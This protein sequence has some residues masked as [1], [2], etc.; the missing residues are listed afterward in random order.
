M[1]EGSKNENTGILCGNLNVA[2][3][4]SEILQFSLCMKVQIMVKRDFLI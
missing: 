1:Y 3:I 2:V 4:K